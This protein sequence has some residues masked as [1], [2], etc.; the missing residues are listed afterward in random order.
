[1]D[2]DHAMIW[3]VNVGGDFFDKVVEG[4]FMTPDGS[5]ASFGFIMVL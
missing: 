4:E 1:M 5:E 3:L 2:E